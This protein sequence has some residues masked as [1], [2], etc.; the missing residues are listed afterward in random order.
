MFDP[1]TCWYTQLT[2]QVFVVEH[3]H[4]F[5]GDLVGPDALFKGDGHANE[6]YRTVKM[7]ILALYYRI[8]S[9]MRVLPWILQARA[10]WI[11]AALMTA[12]AVA[13]FVVRKVH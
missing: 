5:R 10:V 12:T 7:S 3:A 13:S 1:S 11:T 6:M 9:A 2:I 8:G 4:I